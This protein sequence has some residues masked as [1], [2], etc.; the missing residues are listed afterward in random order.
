MHDLKISISTVRALMSEKELFKPK[1]HKKKR[2]FQYRERRPRKGEML[3]M[4]GSPHDWLEGRADKT[5]V[6][7]LS[8]PLC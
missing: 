7:N 8:R 1:R 3:Q 4:D 6:D 5:S 2:I